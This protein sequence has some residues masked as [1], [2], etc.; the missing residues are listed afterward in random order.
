[1]SLMP[2]QNWDFK[3]KTERLKAIRD[4]LR[5]LA[6]ELDAEIHSDTSSY[7]LNIKYDDV[8]EY[9]QTND[10]DGDVN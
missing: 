1:M 9:Y 10:D 2:S 8:L 7:T 5:D 4:I 6:D 3:M